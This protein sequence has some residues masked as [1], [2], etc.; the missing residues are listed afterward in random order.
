MSG[1]FS[2]WLADSLWLCWVFAAAGAGCSRIVASGLLVGPL[3]LLQSESSRALARQL[4]CAG[5]VALRHA[6]SSGTRD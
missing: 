6:G 1:G 5:L 4:P 3:P 2:S